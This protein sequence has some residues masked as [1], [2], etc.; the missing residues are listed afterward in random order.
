MN[1]GASNMT[2]HMQSF[3]NSGIILKNSKRDNR[4]KW[5]GKRET[6][7]QLNDSEENIV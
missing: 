4:R 7:T 3:G 1:C 6:K 2:E 5:D